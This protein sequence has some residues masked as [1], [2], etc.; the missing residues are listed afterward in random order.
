MD[1]H[2]CLVTLV[3]QF[4]PHLTVTGWNVIKRDKSKNPELPVIS[5][6]DE[7]RREGSKS[8]GARPDH[9]AA[10]LNSK[11]NTHA[12]MGK[13]PP[14]CVFF[15]KSCPGPIF[16][17]RETDIYL[18][19]RFSRYIININERDRNWRGAYEKTN[20]KS[21]SGTVSDYGITSG[22][23]GPGRGGHAAR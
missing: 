18:T 5:E 17:R 15:P 16:A 10:G 2:F 12:G 20:G 4:L 13:F 19:K 23:A 11:I 1:I 3:P 14:A 7:D 9:E 22:F 8:T 6:R 21:F